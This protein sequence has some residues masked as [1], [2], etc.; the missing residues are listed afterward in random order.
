MINA[1]VVQA[2]LK[3]MHTYGKSGPKHLLDDARYDVIA[4]E[5]AA[6]IVKFVDDLEYTK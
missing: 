5:L 2:D 1:K 4:K 6:F 3:W